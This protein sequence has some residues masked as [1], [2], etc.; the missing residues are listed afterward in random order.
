MGHVAYAQRMAFESGVLDEG[1]YN[2]KMIRRLDGLYSR[3]FIAHIDADGTPSKPFLL[4]Q[5]DPGF[6]ELLLKSFN[7]PELITGPVT[8][9]PKEMARIAKTD[10]GIDVTFRP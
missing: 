7:V 3:L 2:P 1:E 8:F 10:P 4:P 9:D 5:N 6:N